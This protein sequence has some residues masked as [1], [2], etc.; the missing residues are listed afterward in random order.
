M[1][2]IVLNNS[3]EFE[4]DFGAPVS[5]TENI[6]F[7]VKIVNSTIDE[8]H[9][10]FKKRENTESLTVYLNDAAPGN[11]YTGYVRYCGF[12]VDNNGSITVTLKKEVNV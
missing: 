12:D 7:L 4:I 10:A 6:V 11:T 9:D 2:K 1:K 5:V 3:Q 8:V